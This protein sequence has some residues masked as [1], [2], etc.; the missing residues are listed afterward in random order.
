MK[1]YDSDLASDNPIDIHSDHEPPKD[2][3]KDKKLLKKTELRRF[4]KIIMRV[5]NIFSSSI[6][7]LII[8][9]FSDRTKYP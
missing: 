7:N 2:K 4:H 3:I 8:Y 6:L 5:S 9:F 1:F